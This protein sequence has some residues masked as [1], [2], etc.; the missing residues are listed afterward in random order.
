MFESFDRLLLLAKG[1]K[2]VYF[3]DIG[4]DSKTVREYF[5]RHGAVCPSSVN[6]AEYVL[7]AIGTG[8]SPRIGSRDWHDIWLESAECKTSKKEINEMKGAALSRP[9][10]ET[11][12]VS[13]CAS[14]QDYVHSRKH[15][16]I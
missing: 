8:F 4:E 1:G 9:Q 6:P 7:E 16:F 12:A 3:G 11:K 2:T 14:S 15:R 13:T 10:P 5:A